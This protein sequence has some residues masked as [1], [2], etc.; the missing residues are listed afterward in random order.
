MLA[1]A[2]PRRGAVFSCFYYRDAPRFCLRSC[3]PN[4]IILLA[5]YQKGG[6]QAKPSKKRF[7]AAS[8]CQRSW[9]K[10]AAKRMFSGACGP[11]G[12]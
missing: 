8:F 11:G 7:F 10:E 2:R 3:A 1:L 9:Q 12:E 4:L 6:L 5:N